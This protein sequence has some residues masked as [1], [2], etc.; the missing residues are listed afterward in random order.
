MGRRS[1]LLANGVLGAG[2][3]LC[4]LVLGYVLYH[5]DRLLSGFGRTAF[6]LGLPLAGLV[7][8]AAA[9]RLPPAWRGTIAVSALSLGAAVYAF[10]GYMTFAAGSAD[11]PIPEGVPFDTRTRYDVITDLRR[12][13]T[14][15]YPAVF[16]A[17]LLRTDVDGAL[18]SPVEVSGEEVLP[19][20]GI[21]GVTTVLCNESGEYVIYDSDEYGFNNPAGSWAKV[22]V[23]AIGD[24]FVQGYCVPREQ[25]F[26]SRIG[27]ARANTLNLGTS[28]SGPLMMLAALKEF[29][30][31]LAP[32]VVVWFFF[33]GNDIPGN[34][35]V[36]RRSPLLMRYL[37]EADFSQ[38]LARRFAGADRALTAYI[39]NQLADNPG[40]GGTSAGP[41]QAVISFIGL[42]RTRASLSLP[43]TIGRVDYPLFNRI[44]REA[45]RVVSNWGGALY[46]AYLPGFDSLAGETGPQPGPYLAPV[47][48]IAGQAGIPFIDL[49]RAFAD[50]PDPASLFP[51]RA[52][53][54]YN[55][56]GH[57]LVA[58]TVINAMERPD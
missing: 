31:S 10:E 9:G 40:K 5:Q 51:F 48:A 11:T 4:A 7:F 23:A 13:G 8:F 54:H 42:A 12:D 36:E 29:L 44:L 17:Y 18:R 22:E 24:S 34:L 26:V 37:E 15:A 49:W 33:E 47:R 2:A 14:R 53:N 57:A 35:E 50:H 41:L 45:K 30:P 32:P 46:L 3:V 20:G 21:A 19:L 38:D 16:P 56:E 6:F 28:G 25:N 27:A 1:T 39:D 55:A 52:P 58:R 43:S